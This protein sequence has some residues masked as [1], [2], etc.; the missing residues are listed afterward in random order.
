MK[1]LLLGIV[2]GYALA[3]FLAEPEPE[4]ERLE[5]ARRQDP[6]RALMGEE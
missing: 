3:K 2:I 1:K 4:L 6:G 5:E